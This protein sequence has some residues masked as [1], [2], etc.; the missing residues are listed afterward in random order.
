M[1]NIAFSLD[2]AVPLGFIV[3]E[4]ITNS[5]KHAFRNVREGEIV[6]SLRSVGDR[7]YE[8]VVRDNG[9]GIPPS[10]DLQ[11]LKSFG[12]HL[13]KTFVRQ[14]HG[15][16]EIRRNNGTEVR[17]RFEELRKPNWQEKI[18]KTNALPLK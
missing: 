5:I 8:L 4:I 1:E 16:I 12:L 15:E 6:L 17:V 11:E 18:A 2:T 13:V 9:M 3:T 7:K 10:V 14:L